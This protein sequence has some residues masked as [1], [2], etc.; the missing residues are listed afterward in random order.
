[1]YIDKNYGM[2]HILLATNDMI[3]LR[4]LLY[5]IPV[6]MLTYNQ[7]DTILTRSYRVVPEDRDMI[8]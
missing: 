4:E 6:K 2:Y 7:N 8:Y 5:K 3:K 1:M